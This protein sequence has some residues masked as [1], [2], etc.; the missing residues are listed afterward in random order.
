MGSLDWYC[1]RADPVRRASAGCRI[2][3]STAGITFGKFKECLADYYFGIVY[4]S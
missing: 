1:G 4:A 2:Q 3:Q